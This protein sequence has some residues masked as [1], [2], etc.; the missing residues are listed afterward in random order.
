MGRGD[1]AFVSATCRVLSSPLLSCMCGRTLG[2]FNRAIFRLPLVASERRAAK[3][4]Q[5]ARD[6]GTVELMS[7]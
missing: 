3:K 5:R 1:K 4:E 2:I 6:K 7:E